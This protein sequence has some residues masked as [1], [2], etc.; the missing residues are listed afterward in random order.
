MGTGIRYSV[1]SCLT[2]CGCFRIA[3]TLCIDN[4]STCDTSDR[5]LKIILWDLD[6]STVLIKNT[7]LRSW[8]VLN[9]LQQS[10]RGMQP[11]QSSLLWYRP[12]CRRCKLEMWC[13][14]E[15]PRACGDGGRLSFTRASDYYNWMQHAWTCLRG[16]ARQSTLRSWNRPL[17]RFLKHLQF[18]NIL[19]TYHA[20]FIDTK[21]ANKKTKAKRKQQPRT[22][23]LETVL[24]SGPE[25]PDMWVEGLIRCYHYISENV[26]VSLDKM[27]PCK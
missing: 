12:R 22:S 26:F 7:M 14:D 2:R 24:N 10:C 19:R 17:Q 9:L 16:F 23:P 4:P 21:M 13:Q 1:R 8:V 11:G 20:F 15:V 18:Q 6:I 3:T 25:V 5:R 27:N